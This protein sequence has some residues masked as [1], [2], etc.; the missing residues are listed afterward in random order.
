MRPEVEHTQQN[1]PLALIGGTI[2]VGG[3][4]LLFSAVCF[5]ALPF[6]S[7][8]SSS[9]VASDVVSSFAG[10]DGAGWITIAMVIAALGTLNSS[11][12]SG[13]RVPYA[14]ARDGLFFRVTG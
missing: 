13:A 10:R 6:A 14:M 11:L 12:L 7:V 5:Y 4:Y 8:A 1:I 9:H 2:L 3:I